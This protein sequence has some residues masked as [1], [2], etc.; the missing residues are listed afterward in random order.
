MSLLQCYCKCN[1]AILSIIAGIIIGV[2]AA[3]FQITGA[4]TI[5]PVF[6]WVAFG[7]AVGYLGILVIA[8]ALAKRNEPC[9]CLCSVLN[10]L[11]TGILGTLLLSVILLAFGIIA[12]SVVSAVF[13]GFLLFFFTLLFGSS[14]CFI[15]CLLDCVN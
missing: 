13:A 5:T 7:I 8:A 11:L 3:F 1:C 9:S 15:K 12:T 10:T 6:L 2:L 14:A 4:F